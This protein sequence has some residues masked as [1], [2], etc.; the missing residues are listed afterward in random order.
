MYSEL[1]EHLAKS[2][3]IRKVKQTNLYIELVFNA[4][5]IKNIDI[6]KLFISSYEISKNFKF[7]YSKDVLSIKLF[8]RD[9]DKHFIYYLIE[10]LLKINN[11]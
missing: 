10:L 9:L 5:T 6:E 3:D 4:D 7:N 1:F 11:R 2:I 8:L